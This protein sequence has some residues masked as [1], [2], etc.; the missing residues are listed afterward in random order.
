MHNKFL[1]RRH[2]YLPALKFDGLVSLIDMVD[3]Y[4]EHSK[5]LDF[6]SEAVVIY[7]EGN[8]NEIDIGREVAGYDSQLKFHDQL[9]VKDYAAA[10]VEFHTVLKIKAYSELS[11]FLVEHLA[12][13]DYYRLETKDFSQFGVSFFKREK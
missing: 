12:K 9:M 3:E 5:P 7:G 1:N 8:T 4:I 2:V 11:S 13:Y 6:T 10:D